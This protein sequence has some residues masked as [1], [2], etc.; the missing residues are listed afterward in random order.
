MVSEKA[1]TDLS[2]DFV[3][4]TKC[5]LVNS[6]PSAMACSSVT[7]EGVAEVGNRIVERLK[8]AADET[9]DSQQ[10]TSARCKESLT[11]AEIALARALDLV[12][13]AGGEELIAAEVRTALDAL[14]QVVGT[15][16]TD[17][18]LDRIF[19]QFCIGK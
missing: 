17:D 15:V 2:N 18:I 11:S 1:V 7:G 13:A 19:G 8:S 4:L 12:E 3:V 14:G 16:Y 10:L 5:D 9:P 6:V